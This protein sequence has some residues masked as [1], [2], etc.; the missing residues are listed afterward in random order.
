MIRRMRIATILVGLLA[1]AA[2]VVPLGLAARPV[3]VAGVARVALERP[4]V[5]AIVVLP[6]PRDCNRGRAAW[7][8]LEVRCVIRRTFPPGLVAAA[9]CVAWAE[10][11]DQPRTVGSLGERG[12]FQ[13]HPVHRAWIG[14][15]RWRRMFDPVTNAAVALVLVRHAGWSPWSTAGRC[16]AA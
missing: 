7:T 4:T 3:P 12:V 9:L 5:A 14:E 13:L 2:I 6:T 11:R 10:S 8:P 15:A 16:G 1:L